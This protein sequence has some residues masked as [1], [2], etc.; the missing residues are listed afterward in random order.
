MPVMNTDLQN[1]HSYLFY[2]LVI[3]FMK[4]KWKGIPNHFLFVK[5]CYH[6][7]QMQAHWLPDKHSYV[8]NTDNADMYVLK[9]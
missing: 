8:L 1:V 5:M 9:A 2:R 4:L 3:Q 6:T 7:P